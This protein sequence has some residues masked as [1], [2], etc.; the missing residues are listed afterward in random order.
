MGLDE[1]Y[2]ALGPLGNLGATLCYC[3]QISTLSKGTGST[4]WLASAVG[5]LKKG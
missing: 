3:Q 2:H 4:A 5:S 1:I